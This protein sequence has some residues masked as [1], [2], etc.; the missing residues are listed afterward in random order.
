MPVPSTMIGFKLTTVLTPNGFVTPATAR[1][2]TGGPIAITLSICPLCSP[3]SPCSP[4]S[5]RFCTTSVTNP[6]CPFV[7]SS[8]VM[9]S[10]LLASSIRSSQ[11]RMS[12][13]RAPI[14][15]I[16]LLPAPSSARAI[17][18]IGAIPTPPPTHT[19]VPNFSI[20]DG[21]PS[22][23]ATSAIEPPAASDASWRVVLP[24]S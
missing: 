12:A 14:I 15:E 19:T 17:G 1:I 16:T 5:S 18:K 6:W 11:N 24:I 9:C 2:I 21:L 22:G 8:V 7:P 20:V 10:S 23:P 3:G 13:L 4:R